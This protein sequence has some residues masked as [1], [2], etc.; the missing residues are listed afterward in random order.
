VWKSRFPRHHLPRSHRIC[1]C[2][3]VVFSL[4]LVT[5]NAH[6]YSCDE[7][8]VLCH[9]G[10]C[11]HS[12]HRR[13]HLHRR[14]R[15]RNHHRHH[16]LRLPNSWTEEFFRRQIGSRTLHSPLLVRSTAAAA[17]ESFYCEDRDASALAP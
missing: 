4:K 14:H 2:F 8:Y 1:C 6:F 5:L 3:E 16:H 7:V 11:H 10:E 9:S 17:A 12:N 13:R 15:N